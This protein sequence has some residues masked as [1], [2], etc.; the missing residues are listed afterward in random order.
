MTLDVTANPI[1]L[2]KKYGYHFKY[3]VA[4]SDNDSVKE[5]V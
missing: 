4:F 3:S 1:R 2:K 5:Q